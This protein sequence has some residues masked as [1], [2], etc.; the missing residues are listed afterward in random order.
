M[1]SKPNLHLLHDEN[2]THNCTLGNEQFMQLVKLE[3]H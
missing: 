3:I 1:Q 2:I